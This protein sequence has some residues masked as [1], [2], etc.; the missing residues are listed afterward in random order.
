[1]ARDRMAS[2]AGRRRV[3]REV[4]RERGGHQVPM[5]EKGRRGGTCR[6]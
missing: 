2:R 6:S 1:M 3:R 5:R 4:E